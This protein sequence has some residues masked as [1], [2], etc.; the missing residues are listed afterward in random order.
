MPQPAVIVEWYGPY[1]TLDDVR[2]ANEGFRRDQQHAL[3][4]ALGERPQEGMFSGIDISSAGDGPGPV[5]CRPSRWM[6][7]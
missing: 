2:E 6:T 3:C 7:V 5:P 4:T 1:D